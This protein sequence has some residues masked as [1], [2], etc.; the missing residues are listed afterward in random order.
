V[1]TFDVPGSGAVIG[2]GHATDAGLMLRVGKS[3]S[4]ECAE[5]NDTGS[6]PHGLGRWSTSRSR[7]S[8][9]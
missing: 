3:E 9:V 5:W 4:R 1:V 2:V 6:V 7:I 8:D